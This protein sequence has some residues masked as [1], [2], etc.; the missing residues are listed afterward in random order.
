MKI[1]LRKI[2][3]LFFLWLYF[4]P[5]MA[6][7]GFNWMHCIGGS[8][9]DELRENV[10]TRS[11]L[12]ISIGNTTSTNGDATGNHGDY[13]AL[14]I[15]TNMNGATQWTRVIG[16]TGAD[17]WLGVSI[18]TLTDGN[19]LTGISCASNN[20]DI[21]GNHGGMDIVFRKY[22]T[23][24]SLIWSKTYGG[25]QLDIIDQLV[26]TPDGG[27]ICSGQTRSSNTGNVGTNHS[28]LADIWVIKLD[29]NGNIQWQKCYGGSLNET[30]SNICLA[31]GGGYFLTA[32]T[33]STDGDLAGLLPSGYS[34]GASDVWLSKI[35]AN[36][37]ILWRKLIGGNNTDDSPVIKVIG[38]SL[39]LTF[40]SF[41]TDRNIPVNGGGSDICLFKYSFSGDSLFHKT[42]NGIGLDYSF[43]LISRDDG[44]IY[45]MAASYSTSLGGFSFI[46]PPPLIGI[47]NCQA[48]IM[49]ADSSTGTLL[50]LKSFGGRD[51]DFGFSIKLADN[52]NFI[53]SGTTMANDYEM[54]GNHGGYDGFVTELF[55]ANRITGLVYIDK[56]SDGLYNAST[57]Q[58]VNYLPIETTKNGIPYA[59]TITYNGL[60]Y[61]N[62]DTG[63]FVT[64]PKPQNPSYFT[65][66]PDSVLSYFTANYQ[67]SITNIKM[68]QVPNKRDLRV[69]TCPT[70]EVRLGRNVRYLLIAQNVGTETISSGTITWKND[71]LVNV[72]SYSQPPSFIGPDST[73]WNFSNLK[74]FD[75]IRIYITVLTATPPALAI[76]DTLHFTSR[77]LPIIG[78]NQP[79]DNV[80]TSSD[81]VI[82]PFD[83]NDK[84]NLLGDKMTISQLQSGSWINY[85][86]R[87]QNVGTAS[88]L[89]VVVRDTL[90]SKLQSA[91]LETIAASHSF[92]MERKNNTVTWQF[93]NINLPDSTSNQTG[94]HGFI[95]FRV[96][97]VT[98][99][100]IGDSVLNKASIYFDYNEP[101]M[102][103]ESVV[104][105]KNNSI[106]IITGIGNI[107]TGNATIKVFPN[108]LSNSTLHIISTETNRYVRGWRLLTVTGQQVLA[109]TVTGNRQQVDISF[110]GVATT[111]IYILEIQTNKLPAFKRLFFIR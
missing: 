89:K 57:D 64:K 96:K 73:A 71:S 101:V 12:I 104:H 82:G 52:G 70:N 68:V 38:N 17:G 41:S 35:D 7:Q 63:R 45:I 46:N 102:T 13:D 54:Y 51:R 92:S 42:Y 74:P 95:L 76:R 10:I 98:T 39:Y 83:P 3:L 36:G 88:A 15:A 106:N 80:M 4:I 16:G 111:G 72:V 59:N 11:G 19:I 44:L 107:N 25:T 30:N 55:P 94:S 53:I 27:A 40:S 1:F 34:M 108:P 75:S 21:S 49:T 6:Q 84:V 61:I 60:Y 50:A 23:T 2:L 100:Q 87:F 110:D 5:C 8:A 86:I 58:L 26:N 66:V 31:P 48:L 67:P 37:V 79:E 93:D 62:A 56:N 77:I 32:N 69:F 78:D 18:D 43:D 91:T 103:E 65:F 97:P 9:N 33:E 47:D 29:A 28:S 81:I 99:M 105:I 14:L 109:G 90:S 22:S 20:G 85:M 24:G